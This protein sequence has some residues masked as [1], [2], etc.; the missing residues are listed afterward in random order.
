MTP[1][2][3]SMNDSRSFV[4][5]IR[6]VLAIARVA[7]LYVVFWA[8][9][10][11]VLMQIR[12]G[13][14]AGAGT[15]HPLPPSDS[16]AYALPFTGITV[17][18]EQYDD[19]AL[20]ERLAW[21][22]SN[23]F[24]WVRQRFGWEQ[25]E[26]QPGVYRWESADRILQSIT[27]SG[28]EAVVVLD[29]SPA[30]ARSD[31]DNA[32][33]GNALA[34]P[35]DLQDFA[36]FAGEFAARYAD[37]VRY[38]QIWDE[39][40]IAPH[41]G[42]RWIDPVQYA[43]M[44]RLSAQA[45]RQSDPDAVIL[46]G[47]LAPTADRGHL[48]MDEVYFLERMYAAGAA[49]AFDAVALQPLG[50]GRTP[51]DAAQRRDVLNFQRAALV[52]R[53]MVHAGDGG[54][55]IVAARY[56]WNRQPSSPWGAVNGAEQRAFATQALDLAYKKWPWM[57]AMAWAMDQPLAPPGDPAWGF[58]LDEALATQ[59][60]EWASGQ[61]QA[62]GAFTVEPSR[63]VVGWALLALAALL[64][65]WRIIAAW[66]ILP[67][68]RWRTT[69]VALAP[70]KKAAIWTLL[71]IL[72]YYAVWPPL[73]VACWLAAALLIT[74]R[75]SHGL[76]LAAAVLPFYFQHKDI[77][78][79]EASLAVAP[80]T[81]AAICLLPA[82]L[83]HSAKNRCAMDRWDA[84]A[85][86][87]L[88]VIAFSALGVWYWPGYA[89]G[90]VEMVTT[91]LIL[92]WAVRNFTASGRDRRIVVIALVAG[93]GIV[94]SLGLVDWLRG[95]GTE[96]DAVRRLVGPYFSP[97]HAALYLLRTLFAA[98]GL[99][100]YYR[101]QRRVML[102]LPAVLVASALLLTASRGAVLLGV[103]AG[104]ATLSLLAIVH[105]RRQVSQ[106][107][108]HRTGNKIAVVAALA[109]ALGCGV[110]LASFSW[111][112]LGNSETVV[113][114]WELWRSS[115]GLVRDYWLTGVGTGGFAWR[116]PAYIPVGSS[117]DPNLR[118]PHNV[119][120]EY[121]AVGGWAAVLW[122]ITAIVVVTQGVYKAVAGH[123]AAPSWPAYGL[124]A[125]LGAALAHAHVDA[126]AA[127]PDLA[128]W[129]WLVLGLV[130]AGLSAHNSEHGNGVCA[131]C[132][133][134]TR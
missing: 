8:I 109:L 10:T 88:A 3:A 32:G 93:G 15:L 91:P 129:N 73:V 132:D 70:V 20:L 18:L 87:W 16:P 125:G 49:G 34:P 13:R 116:F 54:T 77:H 98:L 122:L 76:W 23:D 83:W 111:V 133:R 30:W 69:Y 25:L 26:T 6:I 58:S 7:L 2:R 71:L 43:Q 64:G 134:R 31:A 37:A 127:L 123:R 14:D 67:W 24:G 48:A 118:H 95:G 78:F 56:G 74:T 65:G 11:A 128:A 97:N 53:A 35:A 104:A 130:A 120:L 50:Y 45:I 41:W 55:P 39:P 28:L 82:L 113:Q 124:I 72:Y 85:A 42:A 121:A 59:I 44:M 99:I 108:P 131:D 36:G 1:S 79:G 86:V 46:T 100:L 51:D 33:D 101:G 112:R 19:A 103:P 90:V 57:A 84:L 40:N 80:M 115:A 114:R 29:G 38:Y 94:A 5:R 4:N 119:W 89:A 52:R 96:A 61:T 12:A 9:A 68:R 105:E 92:F 81:A 27:E 117:L 106:N 47:A 21:L 75:P 62:R 66:R 63:D 22:R 110:A 102:V 126:F 60:S 107:E 17:E